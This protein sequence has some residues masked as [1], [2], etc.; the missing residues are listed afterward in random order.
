[1]SAT[2][3]GHLVHAVQV[4]AVEVLL[5]AAVVGIHPLFSLGVVLGS[6]LTSV[7]GGKVWCGGGGGGERGRS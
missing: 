6:Q 5:R 2:A 7:G 4:H 3:G 1:M